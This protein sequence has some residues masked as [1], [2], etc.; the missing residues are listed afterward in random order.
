MQVK[1][2]ELFDADVKLYTDLDLGYPLK[3]LFED[4]YAHTPWEQRSIT[5]YDRE[6]PQPRLIAWYS[7]FYYTYSGL[8]LEPKAWTSTL[9]NLTNQISNIVNAPFNGVLLNLYRDGRDSIGMHADDEYEFGEEPTIASL[10]L[11]ATRILKFQR[12]DKHGDIVKTCLTDGSL[13][14]MAGK[15]Q[16]LYKHGID[17]TTQ[18]VGPRI[19][20]TFRNIIRR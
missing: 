8:R 6:I 11:G 19:N 9:I 14:V 15:T 13:L 2:I 12:K 4:L 3:D 20:L 5:L 10:S 1:T 18:P 17:K 7:N 16:K